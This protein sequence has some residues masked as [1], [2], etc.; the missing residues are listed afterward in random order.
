MLRKAV[1]L[2][3]LL[4][5]LAPIG[6]ETTDPYIWSWPHNKRRLRTIFADLH[7]LHKDLDRIVF[8]M[9]SYPVEVDW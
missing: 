8:D 6:C 1:L 3:G 7:E 9:E 2:L 5:L 4:A